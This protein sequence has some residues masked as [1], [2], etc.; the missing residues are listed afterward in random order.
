MEK[1]ELDLVLVPI[2]LVIMVSYH[3][4]LFYRI[5]RHPKTTVLG[6]NAINRVAWVKAM[7]SD[8]ENGILAVQT[9]RNSIMA[10]TLLSTM[11]V[12][13]SSLIVV[14]MTSNSVGLSS[15]GNSEYGGGI[16][17]GNSSKLLLSIKFFAILLCALTAFL[18]FA[19]SVRYSNHT[20]VLINVP[21]KNQAP[22]ITPEYV[23]R[24]MNKGSDF[25]SLGWRAYYFSFP[26]FLW[27]FGPIPMFLCCVVMVFLLYFLDI[28]NHPVLTRA[29]AQNAE[30]ERSA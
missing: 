9:L 23:G 2:G 26:L 20:G 25:W 6:I 17:Y 16:V 21:F 5:K 30:N 28:S 18:L 22:T 7:M 10:A 14:L 3:V 8:P 29:E 12:M 13:L 1:K 19:Q 24:I 4:W 11:A 27:I 15:G